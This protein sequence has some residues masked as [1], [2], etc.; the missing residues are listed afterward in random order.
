MIVREGLDGDIFDI[1][2]NL[3]YN[4]YNH[5]E[6]EIKY[7]RPRKKYVLPNPNDPLSPRTFEKNCFLIQPEFGTGFNDATKRKMVHNAM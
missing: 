2:I 1:V 4:I 6:N 5:G 3:N 7:H